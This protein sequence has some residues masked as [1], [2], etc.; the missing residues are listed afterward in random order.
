MRP[1]PLLI[2]AEGQPTSEHPVQA[3][4]GSWTTCVAPIPLTQF[5][6]TC[7]VEP[8]CCPA[9]GK[10][11]FGPRLGITAAA[12]RQRH[13][14]IKQHG[15]SP[16]R[17]DRFLSR[18]APAPMGDR[19]STWFQRHCRFG[20]VLGSSHLLPV[21]T[22]WKYG[23]S[24]LTGSGVPRRNKAEDVSTVSPPLWGGQPRRSAELIP[25]HPP[26]TRPVSSVAAYATIACLADAIWFPPAARSRR[27]PRAVSCA[28][29]ASTASQAWRRAFEPP[30]MVHTDRRCRNG[31]LPTR[32]QAGAGQPV[33]LEEATGR[34]P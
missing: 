30:G 24:P 1:P 8:A 12:G 9:A 14:W 7:A 4:T 6:M 25:R 17:L 20:R 28:G 33:R 10:L 29:A 27:D 18:V 26:V 15:V 11:D 22:C 32:P 13:S 16:A 19:A 5:W 23:A 21:A 2:L 3:A 34:L 31:P